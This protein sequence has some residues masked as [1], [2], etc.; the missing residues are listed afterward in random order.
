MAGARVFPVFEGVLIAL[1]ALRANKVRASL[2]IL[3]VAVGVFVVVV[4]SGAIH[5]I[6]SSVAKD[7]EKAGPSS[8]FVS[9]YPI[10]LGSTLR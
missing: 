3:G 7:F 10:N 1:D 2:T 4:I 8:F 6:N 5:G 9:R